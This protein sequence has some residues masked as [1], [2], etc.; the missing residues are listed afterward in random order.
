LKKKGRVKVTEEKGK[1]IIEPIIDFLE[2]R[3][4]L[5]TDKPPLS[6]SELHDFVAEAVAKEYG[7]KIK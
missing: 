2:L 3:G 1:I 6:N 4:S 7:K 5:K